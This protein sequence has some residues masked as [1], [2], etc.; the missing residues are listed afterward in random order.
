MLPYAVLFAVILPLT[1]SLKPGFFV[2]RL[3]PSAV[4]EYPVLNGFFR[5]QEAK[6]LCE[7]D[8]E[9]GGFTFRGAKTSQQKQRVYF[10]RL[11]PKILKQE[12]PQWS[13][14]RVNRGFV[15]VQGK[16]EL[17]GTKD[18]KVQAFVESFPMGTWEFGQQIAV[19]FDVIERKVHELKGA[20]RLDRQ[21][22]SNKTSRWLT[23]VSPDA[24][25][26]DNTRSPQEEETLYEAP[27]LV[28]CH[29]PKWKF[30]RDF[31]APSIPVVL[32]ECI[33]ECRK[34]GGLVDVMMKM[35][36]LKW[37][38]RGKEMVGPIKEEPEEFVVVLEEMER[39]RLEGFKGRDGFVSECLLARIAP[40][41]SRI[42][43]WTNKKGTYVQQR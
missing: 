30:E 38:V 14:Y 36:G 37:K 15:A 21:E 33:E 26:D 34:D 8:L 42:E 19:S 20:G 40:I 28:S 23:V 27:P 6:D 29:I 7:A 39:R 41:P 10:Y 4:Y 43:K 35:E 11:V 5:P 13:S 18:E 1:H 17:D 16:G 25:L 32:D 31:V 24:T 2:G 9:C 22:P 12:V 3:A